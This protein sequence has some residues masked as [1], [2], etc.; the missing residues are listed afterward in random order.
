MSISFK[1]FSL[2]D[3]RKKIS[4][5]E[6]EIKFGSSLVEIS[7]ADIVVLG[8]KEDIGPKA[9]FGLTGAQNAFEAFLSK[10]LN[11]QMNR[12]T[13]VHK[14]CVLGEINASPIDLLSIH[15]MREY[16]AKM[17]EFFERIVLQHIKSNQI[18]IVVGGGHNNAYPIIKTLSQRHGALNVLNLDPHAD[19]RPMEGRHSGNSFTYAFKN[20]YMNK[21]SVLGLHK[22]YNSENILSSLDD[23]GHYYSFFED[24][25]DHK[26]TLEHDIDEVI[27]IYSNIENKVGIELD[28]DSIS[29]MPSSAFSPSGV[30]VENAR[31]YLRHTSRNLDVVYLH[32]PEGAPINNTSNNVVG[33][34]L[35]YLVL[36]FITE[37]KEIN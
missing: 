24:W 16:V 33:K 25:L 19:Y 14:V 21:Y 5:R 34:T 1:Q 4:F 18:L 12:Y 27:Q 29:Y 23:D 30:S 31:E 28:L 9:N 17:D 22:Y 11:M 8:I 26:R 13:D 2:D 6:K 15:E 36:D 3:L 37:K 35:A 32:L 10:F 7:E 20:G